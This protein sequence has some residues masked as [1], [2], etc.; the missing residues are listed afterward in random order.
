[1][2]PAV[3]L[4]LSPPPGIPA[5]IVN[6]ICPVTGFNSHVRA[7]ETKEPVVSPDSKLEFKE[8]KNLGGAKFFWTEAGGAKNGPTVKFAVV[9]PKILLTMGLSFNKPNNLAYAKSTTRYP[10]CG[11]FLAVKGERHHYRRL[12]TVIPGNKVG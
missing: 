7:F 8:V 11:C 3:E 5:P 1:V 10:Q 6:Q 4:L 2:I 9:W 12:E